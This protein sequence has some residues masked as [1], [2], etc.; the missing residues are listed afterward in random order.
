MEFVK[1]NM[2]KEMTNVQ[3]QIKFDQKHKEQN[4]EREQRQIEDAEKHQKTILA[5]ITRLNAIQYTLSDQELQDPLNPQQAA[6]PKDED[7][8]KIQTDVEKIIGDGKKA[9]AEYKGGIEQAKKDQEAQAAAGD[10]EHIFS[11]RTQQDKDEMA[12]FL[13]GSSN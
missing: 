12:A 6:A 4:F 1:K 8:V 13:S 2:A 10:G 9:F 3:E 5:D 11:K 7:L